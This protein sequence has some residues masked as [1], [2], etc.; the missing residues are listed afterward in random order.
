MN[1][2]ELKPDMKQVDVLGQIVEV[3]PPR[4]VTTRRWGQARVAEVV[5]KDDSGQ[6]KLVLWD[7]QIDFAKQGRQATI[8]NGYVTSFRGDTQ[9][10]IGRYGQLEVK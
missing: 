9:L 5:L 3:F 6:I 2:S 1:I 7:E 8:T 10:N 4:D